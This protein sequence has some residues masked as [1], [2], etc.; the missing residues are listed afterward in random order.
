MISNIVLPREYL[1]NFI[2][3]H[4]QKESMELTVMLV[5]FVLRGEISDLIQWL[6]YQG[7]HHVVATIGATKTELLI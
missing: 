7:R 3:G 1:G 4:E 5:Y 6:K 2:F